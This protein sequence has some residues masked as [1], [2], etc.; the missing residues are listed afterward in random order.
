QLLDRPRDP[1]QRLT[2][3]GQRRGGLRVI[4]EARLE[5]GHALAQAVSLG[6]EAH[7][8]GTGRQGGHERPDEGAEHQAGQQGRDVHV[9]SQSPGTDNA[10]TSA[11]A[12][13]KGGSS[14]RDPAVV[15]TSGDEA[16]VPTGGDE[17]GAPP[18]PSSATECTGKVKAT[19]PPG[20]T[21]S[22]LP[23]SARRWLQRPECFT[24]WWCRQRA[25]RL[26]GLVSPAGHG[27]AW[28]TSAFHPR[29]VVCTG[30]SQP[31]IRQV[32]SR[33]ATKSR[34]AVGTAYRGLRV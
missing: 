5:V 19:V 10:G 15:P 13:Q 26:A 6:R 33:A 1:A 34:C 4:G 24:R 27:V 2:H 23:S 12:G 31:H 7:D 18:P 29:R 22:V 9:V 20:V 3:R 14:G 28:S 25:E 17:G 8:A 16:L 21:H 11:G 30:R 32:P